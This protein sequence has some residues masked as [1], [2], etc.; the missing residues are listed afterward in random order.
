MVQQL[1]N[2]RLVGPFVGYLMNGFIFKRSFA[3]VFGPK[4]Q[5][6]EEFLNDA[7]ALTCHRQGNMAAHALIMVLRIATASDW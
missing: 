6:S 4:T 7:W 5:P 3:E 2:H 1:L